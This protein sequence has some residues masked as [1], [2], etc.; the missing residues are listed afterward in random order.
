MIYIYNHPAVDRMGMFKDIVCVCVVLKFG[1]L[2]HFGMV[3]LHFAWCLL[4]FDTSKLHVGLSR[5]LLALIQ[6][7]I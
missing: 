1:Y 4:H 2:Q 3:R 6:G 7:V 5:V